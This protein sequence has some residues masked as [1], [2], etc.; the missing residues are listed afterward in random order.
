MKSSDLRP[1]KSTF[2]RALEYYNFA[3]RCLAPIS[4]VNMSTVIKL[5]HIV[6]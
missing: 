1:V 3:E 6:R 4:V 2:K 5:K